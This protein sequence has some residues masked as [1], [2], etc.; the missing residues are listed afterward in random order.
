MLDS[1][2]LSIRLSEIR[3]RLNE[4]LVL[5]GD[6]YTD[7][8]KTEEKTL[9]VEHRDAEQK[10]RSSVI[11]E[12]EESRQQ[13]LNG[14][15]V[16]PEQQERLELRSRANVGGYISSALAGRVPSGAEAELTAAA[17]LE[18]GQIPFELW[19]L[20]P[21][22]R[23]AEDRAVTGSPSSTGVNLDVL[24]PHVFAPSIAGFLALDMP[25][26]ESGTFAT[27]TLS[28]AAT[29]AAKAKSGPAEET[30]ADWTVETSTPHRVPAAIRLTLED[31]ASVGQAN[32]EPLLREHISMVVSDELNNLIINGSGSD[33]EPHGFLS[34]L[35]DA[36]SPATGIE[37]W[38]RILKIQS[39]GIDG[40]WASE[41]SEIGLLVGVDSYRLAASVFQGSDS[42][43]SAAA[44]LQQVGGGF[45][46][47]SKMPAKSSHI[48]KA[49]LCR[50]G[51]SM[52]PT[53][54]RTSV[55]PSWGH[56]SIDDVYSGAAKGER[57][58][59]VSTLVG[60]VHI[61]QPAAYTEVAFRV[62]A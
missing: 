40:L 13:S 57:Q 4:I 21:E 31:I 28:T 24:R 7:E 17:D 18:P 45:V 56:F 22:Q 58:F 43:R 9:Q 1:Q 8:V 19:E 2:R 5:E 29:A 61:V 6:A 39:G 27:G 30:A 36:A 25:V 60:D 47:N 10:Y 53:P 59:T 34:R 3:E 46:T 55:M 26:V 14:A 20:T 35:T 37:T 50:K 54:M 11:T 12:G 41:L 44:Y 62:S 52:T 42:E 38:S 51:R 48:Q 33:N 16:T 32:F 23:Q 15:G 49:I